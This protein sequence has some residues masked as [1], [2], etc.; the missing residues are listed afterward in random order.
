MSIASPKESAAARLSRT[1]GEILW[2][3][4]PKGRS[5]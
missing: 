5:E 4:V 1:P 3:P 2:I